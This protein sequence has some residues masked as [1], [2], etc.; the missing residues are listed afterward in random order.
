MIFSFLF[1]CAGDAGRPTDQRVSVSANAFDSKKRSVAF[2]I[3][4]ENF[5]KP[6]M[7]APAIPPAPPPNLPGVA[8]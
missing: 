7:P 6:P 5:S 1:F 4:F 8:A 3:F 2:E